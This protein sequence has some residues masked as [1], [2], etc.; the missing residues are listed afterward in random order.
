M[1][2]PSSDHLG[3]QKDIPDIPRSQRYADRPGPDRIFS[4]RILQDRK[5]RDRKIEEAVE[6]YG[7]KQR[8]IARHPDMHYSS[9][10]PL[11]RALG[12]TST[13]NRLLKKALLV[14]L[15]GA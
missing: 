8:A 15:R 4:S 3:K 6:K 12:Q 9:I 1:R 2:R 14:S 11:L 7:Y 5:K 10:S 13:F